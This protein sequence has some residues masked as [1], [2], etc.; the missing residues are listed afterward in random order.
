VTIPAVP[1]ELA[2]GA[3]VVH[4]GALLLVQRGR[5]A[6][7][8]KWSIP[9]GRVERGETVREAVAREVREETALTVEVGELATWVEW[10][11]DAH[12]AHHYVILDFFAT[13]RGG[14]AATAG[15][16]AL[17]TRWV[18]VERVRAVDLVDGLYDVLASLGT[19]PP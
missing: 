10:I 1:P 19:V 3:I 5:G 2:V 9:G 7:V 15:D 13:V 12:D 17:D 6:A 18:P 16:D 4:D 8:G 11:G 14:T